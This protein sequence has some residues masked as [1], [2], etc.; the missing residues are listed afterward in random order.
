MATTDGKPE[1]DHDYQL[2][3]SNAEAIKLARE[4]V[5]LWRYTKPRDARCTG[6]RTISP[7]AF[8]ST[9]WRLHLAAEPARSMWWQR[10]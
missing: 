1:P 8:R 10:S 9:I 3:Q 5:D 4:T 6:R 2:Y 7:T